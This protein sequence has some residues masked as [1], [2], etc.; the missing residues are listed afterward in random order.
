[1][2]SGRASMVILSGIRGVCS[3]G[4]PSGNLPWLPWLW[5]HCWPCWLIVSSEWFGVW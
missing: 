4:G 2:V 1:V 3:G 5:Q